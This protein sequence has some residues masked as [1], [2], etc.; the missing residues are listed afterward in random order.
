VGSGPA[1]REAGASL[2]HSRGERV[3]HVGQRLVQ[4]DTDGGLGR[5]AGERE[6]VQRRLHHG[7]GAAG[8]LGGAAERSGGFAGNG[9]EGAACDQL[10]V[11]RDGEEWRLDVVD[12]RAH[13]LA[14]PIV[15]GG[16]VA[17]RVLGRP[18]SA[19][20]ECHGAADHDAGDGVRPGLAWVAAQQRGND[21][22]ADDAGDGEQRDD[23]GGRLEVTGDG[24]KADAGERGG[25]ARHQR[26]G[27]LAG[28]R[29]RM[30]LSNVHLDPAQLS[31]A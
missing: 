11:R 24:L 19:S 22:A 17:R 15:L 2:A 25:D 29:P 21:Q 8:D 3:R 13:L 12:D 26:G 14:D 4:V 10:E 5:L 1:D 28:L 7:A 6:V 16:G 18:V 31:V 20:G 27:G 30:R 23:R 9:P